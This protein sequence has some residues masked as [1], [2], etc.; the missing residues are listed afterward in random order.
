MELPFGELETADFLWFN[1][2]KVLPAELW[3]HFWP[4]YDGRGLG[5][6]CGVL[7]ELLRILEQQLRSY[8]ATDF[9]VPNCGRT[10]ADGCVSAGP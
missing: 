9:R 6:F 7:A 1:R 3:S 2:G 5:L 8:L 10:V 4:N